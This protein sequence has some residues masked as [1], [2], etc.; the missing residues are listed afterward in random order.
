MG[1]KSKLKVVERKL[2]QENAWGMYWMGEHRI[3]ID[4]RQ[5][6]KKYLNTLIHE[7]AHHILPGAS[8]DKVKRIAGALTELLWKM[9]YRRVSQ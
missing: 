6:P 4:P 1:R 7:A 9:K 5:T 2:G 3:E 8:E